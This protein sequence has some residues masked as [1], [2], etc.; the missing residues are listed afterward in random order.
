MGCDTVNIKDLARR[1]QDELTL[2]EDYVL[3]DLPLLKPVHTTMKLRLNQTG[4][5]I[6][7][8]LETEVEEPCDR[9]YEPFQRELRMSFEERFVY[10][11]YVDQFPS[12]DME[13]QAEDFFEPLDL[14]G[15]LDLK[16]LIHQLLVLALSENRICHRT[17]CQ[18]E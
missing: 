15:E 7:G 1:G 8:R 17:A 6:K 10:D 16:D 3:D 18:E 12:G 13:L 2:E 4:V 5:T 11:S 9:C 14:S